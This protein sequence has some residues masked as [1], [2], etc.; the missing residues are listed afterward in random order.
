ME[1]NVSILVPISIAWPGQKLR[2]H[3]KCRRGGCCSCDPVAFFHFVTVVGY[4][5][6]CPR[7][8][9]ERGRFPTHEVP[10]NSLRLLYVLSVSAVQLLTQSLTTETPRTR[11]FRREFTLLTRQ[12]GAHVRQ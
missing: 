7:L 6:K 10:Q 5:V 4:L 11:R 8:N 2:C 12:Q 1:N 9:E 3:R